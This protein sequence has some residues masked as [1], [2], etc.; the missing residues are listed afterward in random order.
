MDR[1]KQLCRIIRG[2]PSK[3]DRFL[4]YSEEDFWLVIE[5]VKKYHLDHDTHLA[6][7]LSI[8]SQM[9]NP[10]LIRFNDIYYSKQYPHIPR[11]LMQPAFEKLEIDMIS[12]DGYHYFHSWLVG[13]GKDVYMKVRAL[14]T[15]L[16]RHIRKID[17]NFDKKTN[18]QKCRFI[19]NESLGYAAMY[20]YRKINNGEDL[21]S[22]LQRSIYGSIRPS[23]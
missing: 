4:C 19:E 16:V 1:F 3:P 21:P 2:E 6:E 15:S 11:D 23:L 14:P 7:L 22:K 20:A 8:L 13:Q 10:E 9:T 18:T 17:K 5:E 12:S